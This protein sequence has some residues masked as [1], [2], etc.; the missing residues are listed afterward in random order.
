MTR[1][2]DRVAVV[3]GGASGIGLAIAQRF[4]A[5]GAQV[6]FT[7][8]RQPDLDAALERIGPRS[9]AGSGVRGASGAAPDESGRHRSELCVDGGMSAV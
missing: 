5:E 7:G 4:A 9:H 3:I 8:R 1:L 2:D 6:Y